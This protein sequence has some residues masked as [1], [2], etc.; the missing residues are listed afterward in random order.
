MHGFSP[1]G[2]LVRLDLTDAYLPQS[3]RPALRCDVIDEGCG[4]PDGEFEAIF[5]RFIQSSKT[6]T[7]AGGTGLG[8]SI[9]KEII[10][11]HGGHIW[12]GNGKEGGAVFSFMIPRV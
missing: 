11:A 4:I 6:K 9:C 7:G 12:A 10:V 5:D 1:N 8:L 2:K 3:D